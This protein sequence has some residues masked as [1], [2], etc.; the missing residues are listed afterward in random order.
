ML[1]WQAPNRCTM[2]FKQSTYLLCA[3]AHDGVASIT[4][5]CRRIPSKARVKQG[6]GQFWDIIYMAATGAMGARAARSL[7]AL[8]S[9]LVR[10]LCCSGRLLIVVP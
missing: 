1:Q 4:D 8:T 5:V 10:L 9:S 3:V 6:L 7:P 2:T